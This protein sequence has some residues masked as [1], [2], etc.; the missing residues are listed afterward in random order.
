MSLKYEPASE[1]LHI[2]VAFKRSWY[3]SRPALPLSQRPTDVWFTRA[4]PGPAHTVVSSNTHPGVSHTRPCVPNTPPG[5]YNTHPCVSDARPGPGH[6]FSRSNVSDQHCFAE[7]VI[8][9]DVH[10]M[11]VESVLSEERLCEDKECCSFKR[12]RHG[13][14]LFCLGRDCGVCV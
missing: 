6:T 13:G 11:V 2:C 8:L 10:D 4:C 7:R 5:V 9:S 3:A 1:P 14:D 12:A